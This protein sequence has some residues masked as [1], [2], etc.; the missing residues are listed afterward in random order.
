MLA[1]TKDWNE[2]K[3]AIAQRCGLT[4]KGDCQVLSQTRRGIL[5]HGTYG[6]V[7]EV[8]MPKM[9]EEGKNTLVR[10]RFETRGD[11]QR[12][13]DVRHE[14]NVL[15]SLSSSHRPTHFGL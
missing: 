2:S 10:K 8:A 4:Q 11:R 14:I 1:I 15:K 3:Q 13:V 5:G 12:V 6:I 7:E 9:V